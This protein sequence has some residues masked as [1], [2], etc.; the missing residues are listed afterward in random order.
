LRTSSGRNTPHHSACGPAQG[1][2]PQHQGNPVAVVLRFFCFPKPQHQGNPVAVVL[3]LFA[4]VFDPVAVVFGCF[5]FG[6]C[7]VSAV[8]LFHNVQRFVSFSHRTTPLA[9]QLKP[10]HQGNPVAVVFVLAVLFQPGCGCWFQGNPVA[11]VC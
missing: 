1:A 10:Q 3:R 6:G 4:V 7:F 9:D 8:V 5:C 11:V 2:T